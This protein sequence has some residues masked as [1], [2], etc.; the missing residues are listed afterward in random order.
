MIEDLRRDSA[1]WRQEQDRRNRQGRSTGM[2]TFVDLLYTWSEQLLGS[3]ADMKGREESRYNNEPMDVDMDDNYQPAAR[4][5]GEPPMIDPREAD[6]RGAVPG[7]RHAMNPPI[8]T[9]YPPEPAYS[10]ASNQQGNY[11]PESLPRS[12]SGGNTPPTS[13]RTVAPGYGQQQFSGR[14]TAPP[15]TVPA[16]AAYRDPRTGQMVTEYAGGYPPERGGRHR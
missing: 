4:R 13:G 8:S 3:Y 6:V 15:A 14:A 1:R 11:G 2:V 7:G 5:R 10:L 12:Y 9:G 16:P